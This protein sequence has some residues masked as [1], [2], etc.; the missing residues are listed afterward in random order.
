MAE[1]V[2]RRYNS[3]LREQQRR[4]TRLRI[5]DAASRLF[6]EHGYPATT[7]EAVAADAGVATDTVYAAFSTK[8]ALLKEVMDV[9][10]A[11][12]DRDLKVYER[13]DAQAMRRDTD[14]RHQIV[15]FAAGVTSR[16]E[17]VRPLDDVMRSAA[18]VDAEVAAL[19]RDVQ[20]R[21]RREG[22]QMFV[23]SLTAN[24]P[25]RDGLQV[26][27]AISITW[28]LT[29][30]EVH[31]LLRV[32]SGWTIERYVRWLTATLTDSLLPRE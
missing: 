18:A 19:R 12:D 10:V 4:Q 2:K 32:D 11:G 3:P 22:M 16:M 9:T 21:Q 30:P 13:E 27:D 15:G 7:M 23:S 5:L 6:L 1:P 17:R 20:L 8:R 28:T 14:Q 26:D 25:L 24:G 31:R 29:S